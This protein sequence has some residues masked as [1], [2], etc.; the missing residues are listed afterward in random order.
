MQCWASDGDHESLE[1]YKCRHDPVWDQAFDQ[2]FIKYFASVVALLVYAVPLWSAPL[3]S[4]GSR[5]DI[6][7]D[8]IR[9][10]RLLQNTS[11]CAALCPRNDAHVGRMWVALQLR[12]SSNQPG[13]MASTSMIDALKHRLGPSCA[14]GEKDVIR[15]RGPRPWEPP[16]WRVY[17]CGQLCVPGAPMV[18]PTAGTV[19]KCGRARRG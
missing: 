11:K 15:T 12:P 4:R 9:A 10:M 19:W 2:Y 7:Q 8:Y 16:R 3:G 14:R 18:A 6:T 1:Q 5:D 13:C 17:T